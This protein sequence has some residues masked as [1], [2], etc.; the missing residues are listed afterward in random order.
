MEYYFPGEILG[1]R[2]PND[3]SKLGAKI[4]KGIP[5]S[6]LVRFQRLSGAS[7]EEIRHILWMTEEDLPARKRRKKLSPRESDRLFSAAKYLT[8]VYTYYKAMDKGKE[9]VI[10]FLHHPIAPDM[11]IPPIRL[12]GTEAGIDVADAILYGTYRQDYLREYLPK[13]LKKKQRRPSPRIVRYS[14]PL[15]IL[16]LRRKKDMDGAIRMGFPLKAYDHFLRKTGFTNSKLNRILWLTPKTLS[17]QRKAGSLSPD[18][19]NRLYRLSWIYFLVMEWTE[20][21]PAEGRRWLGWEQSHFYG[22]NAFKVL[23]DAAGSAA[24]ENVLWHITEGFPSGL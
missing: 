4:R 20:N 22:M 3:F 21:D 2:A 5:F 8:S 10:R 1:V 6:C 7:D 12:M 13:K 24:V 19:S 23:V 15:Y 18:A 16:G 17:E 14:D 11:S 9:E